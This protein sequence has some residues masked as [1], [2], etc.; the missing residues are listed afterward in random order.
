MACS[1]CAILVQALLMIECAPLVT[2]GTLGKD[3]K[4][5][6]DGKG[7]LSLGQALQGVSPLA[8]LRSVQNCGFH[9]FL[10]SVLLTLSAV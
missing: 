4:D 6:K 2:L 3:G 7:A 10:F 9:G 8:G 1:A 5:G